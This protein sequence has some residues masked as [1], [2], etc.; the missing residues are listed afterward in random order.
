ME[1]SFAAENAGEYK[2]ELWLSNRN[3][4]AID[5]KLRI[6]VSVNGGDVDVIHTVPDGYKPGMHGSAV[7]GT[8][9]LEKIRRVKTNIEVTEGVNTVRIIGGDPNIILEK[10]VAYPVGHEPE[11]T[12]FGAPES[13]YTK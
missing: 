10:L 4:V 9:V 1:Y 8:E 13:Y 7:W 5:A 3:P 11:R 12:Y 2:L 6:G